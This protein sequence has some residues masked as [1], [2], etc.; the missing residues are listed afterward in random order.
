MTF[1]FDAPNDPRGSGCLKW[2]AVASFLG[3]ETRKEPIPMWV[4]QMDFAP[5]PPITRALERLTE[6]G[7][8][9]YFT[10]ARRYLE[11]SAT[12]QATRHGWAADPD[13]ML[14]THGLGNAI[15]LMLQTLTEPGDSIIIFTP[16]YHE[17]INK[18]ARNDRRVRQAPLSVGEDGLF[19]WDLEALEAALDGSERMVLISAPHNP[20]GRILSEAE[21]RELAAFCIKHDLLLC[22]DEIHQDIV[23]PG[24]KHIPAAVAAP[25]IMDRLIVMTAASKTFDVAGL[26]TG[27]VTIP[28][29]GL[30]E[31]Y[32]KLHSALDIQPNRAGVDLSVAAYSPEG[33][34]WVDELVLYLDRNRQT[35][36]E[37]VAAIPGVR[38]MP[39]QASYLGWVDFTNTGL[40]EE[41]VIDRVHGEAAIAPSPGPALGIGGEN[42]MRFNIGTQHRNVVAAVE[43]LQEAF[44]DLQ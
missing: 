6:L 33:A 18:I 34:Q 32:R 1:D 29:A 15:G 37:G 14:A 17:F 24:F 12:W 27:C 44:A 43:R 40:S 39:M 3:R 26:R 11:A 13:H 25:E 10:H 8:F 16:V 19:Y 4:A 5:A 28:D 2:D 42:H 38:V 20:A 21:F 30:R 41:E 31:R 7:E 36:C 23:Y 9:G 35:F 22:S